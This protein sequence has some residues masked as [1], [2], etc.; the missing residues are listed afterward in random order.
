MTIP[1]REVDL[2]HAAMTP[3]SEHVTAMR[4]L[5]RVQAP[6]QEQPALLPGMA[7]YQAPE[8]VQQGWYG[9]AS[10]VY[11]LGVALLQLLTGREPQ[12]LAGLVS[13][14]HQRC[15]LL[16]EA[17]DPC[18]GSWPRSDAS[19]FAELALRSAAHMCL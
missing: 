14:A 12:G 15:R 10:E 9:P 8:V 19:S 13:S 2:G 7:A 3:C 11:S 1:F 17:V 18:A 5:L 6:G 16:E 4:T